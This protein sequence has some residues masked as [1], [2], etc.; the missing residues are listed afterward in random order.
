MNLNSKSGPRTWASLLPSEPKLVVR[1]KSSLLAVEYSGRKVAIL[2]STSYTGTISFIRKAF[3]GLQ[4]LANPRI[5]LFTKIDQVDDRVQVVEELW[6]ELVPY[7]SLITVVTSAASPFTI[8]AN[9]LPDNHIQVR[10]KLFS[11]T[12]ETFNVPLTCTVDRLKSMIQERMFHTLTEDDFYL[13]FEGT[14]MCSGGTLASY[15]VENWDEIHAMRELRIGKPVIYLFSPT[16]LLDV[17]VQLSL[18]DSWRFSA[19]YPP[20]PID[21]PS[22]ESLGQAI[23][24]AVDTK[25]DGLLWDRLT[26]REVAYLFWEAHTNPKPPISPPVTPSAEIVGFDPARPS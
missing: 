11:G 14:M 7:L 22:D 10:V 2:R 21:S 9:T 1:N 6:A 20:V 12:E 18:V 24:W 15:G 19:I 16:P 17:R 8:N 13:D 4:Y 25:S 5:Q 26:N 3:G 23:T